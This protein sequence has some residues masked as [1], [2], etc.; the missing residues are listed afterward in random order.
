MALKLKFKDQAH[1]LHRAY[2][3][4][5]KSCTT[6]KGLVGIDPRGSIIFA[7]MLF[8]GAISDNEITQQSGFLKL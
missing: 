3:I 5:T 1:P 2:S 7:S 4:M 6:L 8:S